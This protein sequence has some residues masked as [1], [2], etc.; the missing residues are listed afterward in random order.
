MKSVSRPETRERKGRRS[1]DAPRGL[2]GPELCSGPG[3]ILGDGGH[4]RT[5]ESEQQTVWRG[6]VGKDPLEN[7]GNGIWLCGWASPE[8]F[9]ALGRSGSED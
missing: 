7:A 5:E 8:K 6:S 4:G 9:R 3:P 1:G 2:R